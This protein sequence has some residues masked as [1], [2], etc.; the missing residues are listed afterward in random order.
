MESPEPILQFFK[1]EHLPEKLQ[2]VSKPFC[3]LAGKVVS[4]LPRNPER[5]VALRKLLEAKDAA[6]RALI[7]VALLVLALVTFTPGV[8]L[9]QVPAPIAP[10]APAV[11]PPPGVMGWLLAQLFPLL[12]TALMALLTSV[13]LP[14]LQRYLQAK[15]SAEG[16]TA[17]QKAMAA[18]ALKVE[19]FA[20]LV[21]ADLNATLK[22]LILEAAKD[23]NVSPEE[24]AKLK[25]TAMERVKVLLGQEGL[26]SLT[27]ILGIGAS[28]AETYLS[29]AIEKAVEAAKP[30][31]VAAAAPS[32]QPA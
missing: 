27:G 14:A 20:E 29:G 2:G 31:P 12:A 6:V 24:W 23:G 25:A 11:A 26:A 15:A 3:E 22:P 1:F 4:D 8:A 32:P 16:A 28:A 7:A 19:H 13:L 5:S 21:V 17:A 30:A 10:P 18:V 9:A